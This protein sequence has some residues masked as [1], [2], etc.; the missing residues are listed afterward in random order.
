MCLRGTLG[1]EAKLPARYKEFTLSCFASSV[2]L[3]SLK[4]RDVYDPGYTILAPSLNFA[5]TSRNFYL[6]CLPSLISYKEKKTSVSSPMV[7]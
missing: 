1:F 5:R 6:I 3:S 2:H 4:A 7:L